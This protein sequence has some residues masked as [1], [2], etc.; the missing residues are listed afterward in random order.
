MC[1]TEVNLAALD[2]MGRGDDYVVC[3]LEER[4]GFFVLKRRTAKRW[5]ATILFED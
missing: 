4:V 5:G 3:T 1:Y 2:A